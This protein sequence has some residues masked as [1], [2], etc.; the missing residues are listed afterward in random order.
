VT[1]K[2]TLEPGKV[3]DVKDTLKATTKFG[4]VQVK[5]G[6]AASWANIHHNGKLLGIS[7]V[8]AGLKTYQLP[9]GKQKIVLINPTIGKQKTVVVDVKANELTAVSATFE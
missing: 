8:A 2:V 5:V 1:R 3:F 7:A 9:V 6:G 4:T